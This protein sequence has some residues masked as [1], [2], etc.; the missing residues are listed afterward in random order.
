MKHP[1]R[2][3]LLAAGLAIFALPLHAQFV[4]KST[5]S[6]ELAKKIAAR[7]EAEAAKNKL[8]VV[9]AIVDDGGNICTKGTEPTAGLA[10][11]RP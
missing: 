2:S 1:I 4:A 10:C 3:F 6:L 7:A 11:A 8:T 5:L 9:V